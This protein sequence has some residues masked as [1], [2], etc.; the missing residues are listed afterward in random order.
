MDKLAKLNRSQLTLKGCTVIRKFS[1]KVFDP[2]NMQSV[3]FLYAPS[4]VQIEVGDSPDHFNYKSK[5]F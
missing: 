1:I 3:N 2:S 4:S 5:V